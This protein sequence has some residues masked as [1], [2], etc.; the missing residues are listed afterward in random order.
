MAEDARE[1]PLCHWASE[2][3]HR[4]VVHGLQFQRRRIALNLGLSPETAALAAL[5]I[6]PGRTAEVAR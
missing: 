5:Q 2:I 3:E 6:N 1:K 4:S